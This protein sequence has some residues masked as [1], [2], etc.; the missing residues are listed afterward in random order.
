MHGVPAVQPGLSAAPD[1][2]AGATGGGAEYVAQSG[3]L[4]RHDGE[5]AV[6]AQPAS[7]S[8]LMELP[9]VSFAPRLAS[10]T[11]GTRFRDPLFLAVLWQLSA[12]C[13]QKTAK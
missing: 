12:N 8:A 7:Q 11:C 1:G 3:V 9:P 10:R 6:E 5:T 4:S 13:C 2:F